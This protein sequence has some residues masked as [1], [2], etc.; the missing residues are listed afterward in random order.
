M[1][2][3]ECALVN[4]GRCNQG[5]RNPANATPGR[6]DFESD[7]MWCGV[8]YISPDH[9]GDMVGQGPQQQAGSAE[10]DSALEGATTRD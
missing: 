4:P 8:W 9:A 5:R 7:A 10:I 1:E 2:E 3:G 6:P